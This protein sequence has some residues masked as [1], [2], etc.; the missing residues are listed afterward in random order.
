MI[1][2]KS[3][4]L[5]ARPEEAVMSEFVH[6]LAFRAPGEPIELR[7]PYNLYLQDRQADLYL[8]MMHYAPYKNSCHEAIRELI[9]EHRTELLGTDTKSIEIIDLGPG[10]PDK[11]FPLLD[12]V[13][14][15]GIQCRYI[16]VDIS[17]RFLSIASDACQGFGVSVHAMH[18][19]FE[20]LP[21]V[22]APQPAGT[23]RLF[24]M[25]VTFMN[26]TAEEAV[27]LLSSLSGRNTSFLVATVLLPDGP[28]EPVLAPYRA[29]DARMFNLLPLDI[30]GFPESCLDYF[31]RFRHG[32]VE[33]GFSVMS[34]VRIQGV[35]VQRGE[36]ILTSVSHRYRLE[37]FQSVLRQGFGQ[38]F[39]V[40]D[41]GKL[42]AIAKVS[43][44]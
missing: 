23:H 39:T 28:V 11:T 8:K 21:A 3:L 33:M 14:A 5:S 22:L 9:A 1:Q 26:Y 20:E 6:N 2:L 15:R 27:R 38:V 18:C 29:A 17:R 35:A 16:P 4:Q 31:V 37:D 10:Y 32:R 25:G 12:A 24:I 36:E 43:V 7:Q 19:L 42:G 44:Q 30:A 34:D 41:S 40:A 13:R